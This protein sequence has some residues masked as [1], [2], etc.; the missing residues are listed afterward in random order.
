MLRPISNARNIRPPTIPPMSGAREE[1]RGD[2]FPVV[3]V[4]VGEGFVIREGPVGL[5]DVVAFVRTPPTVV[6]VIIVGTKFPVVTP[7]VAVGEKGEPLVGEEESAVGGE[8]PGWVKAGSSVFVTIRVCLWDV[9]G[10]DG[11]FVVGG[12]G[13]ALIGV[14][15]L[16]NGG[17]AWDQT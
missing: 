8:D 5:P 7:G 12:G 16:F 13:I 2:L 15:V 14:D 11:E 17:R 4:G 9:I 3:V 6:V 10:S 1:A